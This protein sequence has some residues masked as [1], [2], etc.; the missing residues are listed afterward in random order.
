MH[1]K[2]LAGGAALVVGATVALGTLPGASLQASAQSLPDEVLL[3]PTPRTPYGDQP[4]SGLA[5]L[6]GLR[7]YAAAIDTAH[8][9]EYID[10]LKLAEYAA[11]QARADARAPSRVRGRSS[12]CGSNFEC[13]K[14]CTTGR[15]SHGNYAAVSGSGTYR[16]AWQ[17]DQRTWESN[18]GTGD[19]AAATP[20]QQDAVA[21]ATWQRRGTQPW[22]GMC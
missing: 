10:T 4:L 7:T 14:A 16:G 18:G 1:R 9:V 8:A 12:R 11:A 15:E 2:L 19:P 22:G 5:F 6:E 13:F 21:Q 3:Q 17:F 20:A